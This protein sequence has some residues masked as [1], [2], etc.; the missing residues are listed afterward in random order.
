MFPIS[1][2]TLSNQMLEAFV[3]DR[4]QWV[5]LENFTKFQTVIEEAKAH[6]QRSQTLRAHKRFYSQLVKVL[7]T[8]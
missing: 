4:A 2:P 6:I 7:R 8:R 3:V 1:F 5:Y